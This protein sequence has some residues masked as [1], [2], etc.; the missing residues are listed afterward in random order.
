MVKWVEGNV[1][2]ERETSWEMTEDNSKM[3]GRL[4][5]SRIDAIGKIWERQNTVEGNQRKALEEW[6]GVNGGRQWK[7]CGKKAIGI[8]KGGREGVG[9]RQWFLG[10]NLRVEG[11]E[12]WRL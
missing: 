3:A 5:E 10:R 9:R 11:R 7:R 12:R 2:D 6:E 8:S 1:G 4:W